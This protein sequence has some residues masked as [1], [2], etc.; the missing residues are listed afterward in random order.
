[1]EPLSKLPNLVKLDLSESIVGN[2]GLAHLKKLPKLADLNLWAARVG[3]EGMPHLAE[4]KGLKRLNLDHVRYPAE[5]IELTDAGVKQLSG[6]T[7]LEFLHL[8]KTQVGDEG[9]AAIEGLKNLNLL[10]ITFCPN[11]SDQAF[12]QLC[13]ALPNTTID[14]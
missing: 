8:G 5:N 9:L 7:N 10:I 1:M 4:M 2:A 13:Q 11:I 14:R 3:D 12:E 6:L